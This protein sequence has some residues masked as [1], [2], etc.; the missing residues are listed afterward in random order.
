MGVS[1]SIAAAVITTGVNMYEGNQT[2]NQASAAA[3]QAGQAANE[4]VYLAQQQKI[5]SQNAAA[6]NTAT[7]Q[8]R[9]RSISDPDGDT[10]MTNPLGGAPPRPTGPSGTQT[11]SPG[12]IMTPGKST[13]GG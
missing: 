11:P 13:I 2:R 8:A 12:T 1:G 4:Q 10:I 7:A 3:Q 9:V 6:N 5:S